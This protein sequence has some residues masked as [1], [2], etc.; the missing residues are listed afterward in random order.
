M[1][2]LSAIFFVLIIALFTACKSHDTAGYE[3]KKSALANQ[4]VSDPT[5]FLA[6]TIDYHTNLI[7]KWVVTGKVSNKSTLTRYTNIKV[8][9]SYLDKSNSIIAKEDKTFDDN[10]DPNSSI[11]FKIKNRAPRGTYSASAMVISA[12]ATK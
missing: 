12:D 6:V 3:Q 9:I 11:T 10:I 5:G 1:K 2:R 4:E 7:G 8:R